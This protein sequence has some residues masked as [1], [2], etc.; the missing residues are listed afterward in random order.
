MSEAAGLGGMEARDELPMGP[1]LDVAGA[2]VLVGTCSWTDATLVKETSWYP[3][4]SMKAADRLA[5]YAARYP[6]VEVDST[7]YFPPTP[8]LAGGWVERTPADFTMNV[9]AWSLLTGHPTFPQ[10]LW[11]DLQSEVRPEL[12]DRRTLYAKHMSVDALDEA[13]DR[14]RHALMPLHSAGK[15]GAVLFQ[16][17]RWFG[18]KE[19]HRAQILDAQ[20]K[21][22]GYRLCVE[23]RR[24][25]WLAPDE[26][27]STLEFL[28]EHDLSFVCVDEPQGFESSVPPVVAATSDLA[29]VRFHGRNTET[30]E[31]RV[32]SA[33]ERFRYR[34]QER[35]LQEWVPKLRELAGSA[36][37]VHVLMNNCWRDDAVVNASELLGLLEEDGDR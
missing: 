4:K 16:W 22:P 1:V 7:Y 5:F 11:P 13:W 12:R 28:D 21:L 37:E 26:C 10:S 33:A 9:K 35:E 15:L 20:R 29:V 34:Y 24:G 27:E 8:E 25:S 19:A 30:W 3:R 17:P 14:F 6:I 23:F 2:R 36:R 31:A 18:P 32:A